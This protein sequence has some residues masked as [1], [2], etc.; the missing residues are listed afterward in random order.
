[1]S[2]P[3]LA[4]R[5]IASNVASVV[6]AADIL[7]LIDQSDGNVRQY[8]WVTGAAPTIGSKGT[9]ATDGQSIYSINPDG[10]A[11]NQFTAT[12]FQLF[13]APSPACLQIAVVDGVLYGVIGT[14]M[15]TAPI[16]RIAGN[17]P[18]QAQIGTAGA[19]FAGNDTNL[20]GLTVPRTQVWRY[21]QGPW[22][23]VL[24]AQQGGSSSY[25]SIIA[26]GTQV[27]G[28]VQN[29]GGVHLYDSSVDEA[30][31]SA[32]TVLADCGPSPQYALTP[33]N[34]FGLSGST[35]FLF[36][37]SGSQS[38]VPM[39]SV[40][41]GVQ[42][43]Y[44][45]GQSLLGIDGSGNLYL[46]V[47]G[48]THAS[49]MSDLMR[50]DPSFGNQPLGQLCIPGTHDSGC[51][52]FIPSA[53]VL[54]PV[55]G[56]GGA[57]VSV[58]AQTQAVSV[59]QQLLAGARFFDIRPAPNPFT[60]VVGGAPLIFHG[61][62]P[63]AVAFP[64]VMNDVAAFLADY[65]GELVILYLN[66]LDAMGSGL[67][68]LLQN[69]VTQFQQN[70]IILGGAITTQTPVATSIDA[71]KNLI[72]VV[73]NVPL[74]DPSL[75]PNFWTASN[76]TNLGIYANSQQVSDL[77]GFIGQQLQSPPAAPWMLQCQMTPS[78]DAV[79]GGAPSSWV[80]YL[81]FPI[82]TAAAA[83]AVLVKNLLT[84]ADQFAPFE[85]AQASKPAVQQALSPANQDA[86]KNLNLFIVDYYDTS[87]TDLA[88]SMNLQRLGTQPAAADEQFPAR[89][90]TV[91]RRCL[92]EP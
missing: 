49:W 52:D 91:G 86:L 10:L 30:T 41:V 38:W 76:I 66:H 74:I 51:Y 62:V 23:Q 4:P 78:A 21:D 90:A 37:A 19:M 28:I 35:I 43:L 34:L 1:M 63:T 31:G 87:W 50:I 53:S 72:I 18:S 11:I 5:Q 48:I 45:A 84:N 65:P 20:Y 2:I 71:G 82:Q 85:M 58:F 24:P 27:A 26:A 68:T 59:E 33:G 22:V 32:V 25:G 15:S 13:Y 39:G 83:G 70:L 69:V 81:L 89:L 73:D 17:P 88:V 16:Y 57:A 92:H 67:N 75:L 80:A 12:G 36:D 60:D 44:G 79:T 61:S 9:F 7:L 55:L 77:L 47:S 40:P 56:I 46:L 6:A 29:G 42:Q 54:S 64:D 3:V 8:N 14:D